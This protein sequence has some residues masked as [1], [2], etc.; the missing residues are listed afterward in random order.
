MSDDNKQD[1]M[2]H[3]KKVEHFQLNILDDEFDDTP[4][5]ELYSDFRNPTE[6]NSKSSETVIHSYSDPKAAQRDRVLQRKAQER[7]EKEHKLRNKNKRKKNR[8]LFR[9]MWFIMVLLISILLS[10][11]VTTGISDMLAEGREKVSVTVEMPKNPTTDQVAKILDEAGIIHDVNFF[12]LYSKLTKADGHYNNGSY[13]IDTSMDY[14]AIINNLQSNSNRVDTIKITFPEGVNALEIAA[15]F[16]KNGVC[17]AKDVLAVINSDQ[18]DSGFEVIKAIMNSKDR[19][20]K[21][22]GYLF[23]DTYEFYKDEDPKTAIQKMVNN[24]NKKLTAEIRNKAAAEKMT[25]DQMMTLASMIQAEAADKED[26]Y[27]ISS[28]FH[29]R[30]SS[31]K[32]DLNR[33]RSD[34]TTYYPYRTKAAIPSNLRDTYKSKYDTYTIIGLPAGP[35]CNP[36]VEAIDAALNPADTDYYYFCHDAKGKA[37][38][39]KTNAEHERNLVKAGLSK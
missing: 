19:Y 33:L 37:Y 36:G 27:K 39:A 17:T 6:E 10:Q 16:E 20:Y 32:G 1:D 11:L 24:C 5:T 38:Y 3:R 21:T 29:N 12:K 18:F 34:P 9:T 23:P 14:E 4:E 31:T 30:L 2:N 8:F 25:V 28:V 35:I 7:A 26:M 15:L 13:K 22:E